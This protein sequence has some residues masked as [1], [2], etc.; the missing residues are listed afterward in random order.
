M[1]SHKNLDKTLYGNKGSFKYHVGYRYKNEAVLSP[2][3]IKFP[4][5][6]GYAKHFNNNNNNNKE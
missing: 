1:C 5:L 2:L 4:Q 6:T 3:N